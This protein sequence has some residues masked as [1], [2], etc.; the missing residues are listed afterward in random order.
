M[1]MTQRKLFEKAALPHS[2]QDPVGFHSISV[3]AVTSPASSG[4]APSQKNWLCTS[5]I[6]V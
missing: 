1:G 2:N 3:T 6:E 4:L 5:T